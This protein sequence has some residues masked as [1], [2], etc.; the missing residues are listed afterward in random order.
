MVKCPKCG[1]IE[2]FDEY[3]TLYHENGD[4]IVVERRYH[5]GCCHC[6]THALQTYKAVDAE[7]EDE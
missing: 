7:E 3:D 1:S 4:N 2:E 5:C 6:Y